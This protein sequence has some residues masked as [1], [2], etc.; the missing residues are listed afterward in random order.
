[1]STQLLNP[2]QPSCLKSTWPPRSHGEKHVK[3]KLAV[4][5]FNNDISGKFSAEM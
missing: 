5:E 3:S 4:Q 2:K 1:M